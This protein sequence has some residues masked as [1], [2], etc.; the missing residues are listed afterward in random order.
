MK[1]SL[2]V[3]CETVGGGGILVALGDDEFATDYWS[4]IEHDYDHD[5]NPVMSDI[6]SQVWNCFEFGEYEDIQKPDDLVG[7]SICV[8]DGEPI[9]EEDMIVSI[10]SVET[11][12]VYFNYSQRKENAK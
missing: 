7:K 5:Y 9:Y 11:A 6:D 10:E 8:H 1:N 4:Y 2:V 12:E 3:C